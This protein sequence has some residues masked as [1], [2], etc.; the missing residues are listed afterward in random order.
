[1]VTYLILSSVAF[2]AGAVAAVLL[3]VIIGIHR[4]DHGKRLTGWPASNSETFARRLL[5]G[6][7]G[8]GSADNTGEGQ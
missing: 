3:V 4:S 5:T 1:M 6:S 7:R 2:M 8:Y